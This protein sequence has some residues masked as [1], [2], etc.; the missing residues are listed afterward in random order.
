MRY[1]P[2]LTNCIKLYIPLFFELPRQGLTPAERHW[3]PQ[4]LTVRPQFLW[5]NVLT[6]KWH[7]PSPV[8]MWGREHACV[9]PEDSEHLVW[10]PL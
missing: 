9:F 7:S 2:Q 4:E 6:G 3:Q 10:V 8:L 1:F 5:K